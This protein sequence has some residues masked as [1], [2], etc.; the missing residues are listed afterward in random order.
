MKSITLFTLVVSLLAGIR[1]SAQT[2]TPANSRIC[3]DVAHKQ[4]FWHDPAD[5][6]GMDA[7]MIDRVKYMT[8]ELVKTAASVNASLS[9]LKKEITPTGLQGCD[10]VFI[11]IPSAKYTSGEV[12]ALSK[13]IAG[14]GSLFLVMDQDMWSTLEQA[15]VNDIIRP[16]GIQFGGESPD[17]LAGGHTKA[18]L[19]T[20]K[21]LKISYHGARTVTGGTP[22][23]FNDRSD[24]NPF[25][26][27]KEVEKGGKIVVMGDGMVSL[28]MTTWEGVQDYQCQ[29]FMQDVFRWLLK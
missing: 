11:H 10:L 3:M 5:M 9:Y 15:N 24:A 12:S 29:E 4:R 22:F 26:T 27:F 28:Y 7:K 16:F 17:S 1:A 18:G 20:D 19:I 23:C 2:P 21:R 14:G 6:P 8:G 25:G 13:Y